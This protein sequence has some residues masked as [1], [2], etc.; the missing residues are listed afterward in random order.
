[1]NRFS[2]PCLLFFSLVVSI[3]WAQPQTRILFLLDASGSMNQKLNMNSRWKVATQLL[4][5][6]AD[7]LEKNH[8]PVQIG[9]RVFG[10]QSPNTAHNCEDSRLEIPFAKS[11]AKLIFKKLNSLTPQGYTPIAYSIFKAAEGDFPVDQKTF[12]A[13]ILITDG[14]ETC[15]GD[16]CAA[17][18][19]LERKRISLKPFI[20]GLGL[21][22]SFIKKFNCVGPYFDA[23]SEQGF[24]LILRSVVS[25]I[26]NTTT[27]QINLLNIAAE[28]KETNIEVTITDSY[29]GDLKY[30][31]EHAM[32]NYGI[33]DTLRIDPIGKYD[34]TA[35]TMP[36]VVKKE[37]VLTPGRHN[38]VGLDVPQGVLQL[39]LTGTPTPMSLGIPIN[40]VIRK[41]NQLNIVNVQDFN[42]SN[43]Y[44]IG[45]Y[46]LEILTLPKIDMRGV[47]I[48]S[49]E[50]KN[51]F[52]PVS[53]NLSVYF[54]TTGMASIYTMQLNRWVKVYDWGNVKSTSYDLNLQPGEYDIVFKSNN[55]PNAEN[56]A[57]K[58]ILIES[59]K[60]VRLKF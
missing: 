59:G 7:S 60:V 2:L 53:G 28:A 13:I 50:T 35:H 32:N 10:H 23:K 1:M 58:H 56:T 45:E 16:P 46:D 17:S 43:R 27:L 3:G 47:V 14:I 30:A 8:S 41:S 4:Y 18:Q 21:Q 22:D 54:E 44:L 11:S 25:Q 19:L 40:T 26:M 37:I 42:T 36:P 55:K 12:N 5:H 33:S 31:Y 51:I 49:N 52:I 34:I 6:L 24:N 39:T 38:I 15:D 57:T 29:T 20:I 9:I 48:A